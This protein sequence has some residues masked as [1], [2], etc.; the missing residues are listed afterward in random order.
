MGS[1]AGAEPSTV[2]PSLAN[3]H[4]AQVRADTHHNE[5]LRLLDA[6]GVGLGIAQGLHFDGVGLLNLI[7]SAVPNEDGLAAPLD[8]DVLALR[9]G[10]EAHFHLRHG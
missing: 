10:G 3:G 6:L 8:D 1:V 5:P 4:A 2:V 9:D 7:G